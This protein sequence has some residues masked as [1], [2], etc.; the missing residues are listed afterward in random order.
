MARKR[1]SMGYIEILC[2]LSFSFALSITPACSFSVS[3]S[4]P[5]E[6]RLRSRLSTRFIRSL[7]SLSVY[8][9]FSVSSVSSDCVALASLSLQTG[10]RLRS[11]FLMECIRLRK[12]EVIEIEIDLLAETLNDQP[13]FCHCE[14]GHSSDQPSSDSPSGFRLRFFLVH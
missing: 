6:W 7:C 11:R 4:L 14:S 13:R 2:S 10:W 8:F 1:F 3:L 5:T 9:S 12:R